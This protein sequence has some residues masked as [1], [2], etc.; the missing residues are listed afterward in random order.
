MKKNDEQNGSRASGAL[1]GTSVLAAIGAS[2]CCIMPILWVLVGIG[3]I[4]ANFSWL[5]PLRPY[6][7]AFTLIALVYAWYRLLSVP[8]AKTC[9]PEES[10]HKES[11]SFIRSKTSMGIVTF[12]AIAMLTFPSYSFIFIQEAE[13]QDSG[14]K[15]K[16]AR[17]TELQIEGMTCKGC[18]RSVT[19]ILEQEEGVLEAT[20]SYEEKSGIIQAASDTVSLDA[21]ARRLEKE[22]SYRVKETR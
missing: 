10:C 5:E 21:I 20:A 14:L 2:L 1:I 4:A 16:S 17:K 19:R 18:E 8:S 13:E 6:L 9:G 15:T 22:S 7:V 11:R 3:G 12:F